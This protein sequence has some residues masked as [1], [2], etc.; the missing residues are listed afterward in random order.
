MKR[1]IISFLAILTAFVLVFGGCSPDDGNSGTSQTGGAET[2]FTDTAKN[3][4]ELAGGLVIT[5]VFPYSGEYFEDGSDETC[6]DVCAVRLANDSEEQYQYIRFT[7]RT[8]GGSYSFAASTVLPGTKMTVLC[9]DRAAFTD[10]E[11]TS[12]ELV[13]AAPFTEPPSVHADTL[14]VSWLDGFVNVKNV[15]GAPVAGVYVYYKNTDAYGFLG[16]ITYR[17][18]VGDIAA[19][20]IAQT[21]APHIRKDASQVVFVTYGQ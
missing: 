18:A 8:A 2:S 6:E 15:T 10:G 3:P 12:S 4:A 13:T 9:E 20:Q 19:G 5:D 7:L 11:I 17:A 21:A 16:G 14:S 1:R